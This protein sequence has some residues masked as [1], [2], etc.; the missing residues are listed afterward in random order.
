MKLKANVIGNGAF[1]KFLKK[2]Y[3]EHDPKSDIVVLAVPASA[4]I[5]TKGWLNYRKAFRHEVPIYKIVQKTGTSR[6]QPWRGPRGFVPPGY[7]LRPIPK[8]LPPKS[9]AP[10]AIGISWPPPAHVVEELAGWQTH[11][12]PP[13]GQMTKHPA[14]GK[15]V[16]PDDIRILTE[17]DGIHKGKLQPYGL[18]GELHGGSPRTI[19]IEKI[20]GGAAPAGKELYRIGG[21]SG[22]SGGTVVAS[23]VNEATAIAKEMN[24][25]DLAGRAERMIALY[26]DDLVSVTET[27]D[28][29]VKAG[30][31]IEWAKPKFRQVAKSIGA[32]MAV[33]AVIGGTIY[34]ADY[35]AK[36]MGERQ[37]DLIAESAV[38]AWKVFSESNYVRVG[39]SKKRIDQLPET[40]AVQFFQA[41]VA[42]S[43]LRFQKSTYE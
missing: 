39:N 6:I 8:A 13:E 17:P 15:M 21:S 10:N 41:Y 43:I 35:L 1:G 16:N 42:Q 27:W 18:R 32:P 11:A 37:R 38:L 33:A 26:G 25:G 20:P 34:G 24:G 12:L 36:K 14:T 7:D 4:G 40:V 19:I 30:T 5:G 22:V 9:V 2:N 23:S 31:R 29:A 3:F 28:E